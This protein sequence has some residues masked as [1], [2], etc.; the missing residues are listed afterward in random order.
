MIDFKRLFG[1]NTLTRSPTRSLTRSLT[2]ALAALL[3]T[4]LLVLSAC[5]GQG[6]GVAD[7]T[8]ADTTAPATQQT[9]LADSES[10]TPEEQ[11]TEQP[12]E[13]PSEEPSEE[14]TQEP[15]EQTTEQ[16]A[17]G[18]TEGTTEQPTTQPEAPTEPETEQPAPDFDI[19][20][21]PAYSGKDY[22]ELNNNIPWF[23]AAEK[24]TKSYETY[25]DLDA[26]GRC[27]VVMACCGRDLM[28]TTDRGNISSI[29]PTGWVQ[30]QYSIVNGGNLYNRCH[31]IG[32]QITGE[33]ANANN[34]ITGTRYFNEN[35]IP[36]ENMIADYIKETNNHV[37]YRVTPVFEGNNLV[38]SGAI[39]EAWSVEDDG[40]GICFN[41]YLYNVQP[42]VVIDY[43]TGE[44]YLEADGGPTTPGE[45]TTY[46]DDGLLH[47]VLNK[48]SKKIHKPNCS[49]VKQMSEKN[50]LEF[51]GTWEELEAYYNQGYKDCGTCKG[52]H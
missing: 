49:G 16:P 42:G 5:D 11:P 21:L 40:D 17:Q 6:A 10:D 23:T 24:V 12:S 39:M 8:A 33:D 46:P 48:S 47:L 18:T 3:L 51:D 14:T 30:A 22:V 26:L 38:A 9:T 31:L 44:S 27:T 20:N 28:P 7:T 32:W 35:M 36:Y 13:Q 34:L 1:K 25:G 19:S 41:V 45:E 50:K 29:K 15:T 4:L 37:M 52:A 43:A 2:R